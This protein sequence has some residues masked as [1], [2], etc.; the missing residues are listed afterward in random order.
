MIQSLNYQSYILPESFLVSIQDFKQV[1]GIKNWR[2]IQN[3]NYHSYI[4]PE[5][6]L[7]SIQDFKQVCGIKNLT[8]QSKSQ[9]PI[10]H[11]TWKLFSFSSRFWATDCYARQQC[12]TSIR[13][14]VK[15]GTFQLKKTVSLFQIISFQ[16]PLRKVILD[17][18]AA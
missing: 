14:F 15:A 9:L 3:L 12:I 13:G 18:W 6:F 11:L 16:F 10:V 4:L 17:R 7:A 8:N 1:C 5:N 2:F